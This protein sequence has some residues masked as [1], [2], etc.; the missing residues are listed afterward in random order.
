[1]HNG[2]SPVNRRHHIVIVPLFA[3]LLIIACSR[4]LFL[5]EGERISSEWLVFR[6]NPQHSGFLPLDTSSPFSLRWMYETEGA[7][8]SSPIIATGLVY[9]ASWDKKIH[10]LN[11][12]TGDRIG[13]LRL[14]GSISSTPVMSG[15]RLFV[16]SEHPDGRM[17]AFNMISG[18]VEW[19]TK[20]LDINSSPAVDRGKLFFGSGN[21]ALYAVSTDSGRVLWTFKTGG[22]VRSSPLVT[23]DMVCFG[24]MDRWVYALDAHT[25]E[26]VWKHETR[27]TIDSSPA[28]QNEIVY[29]G[30][31]DSTLYALDTATGNPIWTVQT[32]GSIHSSPAVDESTCY[33]GSYDGSVYAI[34]AQTGDVVWKWSTQSII[35]S[36]PAVSSQAVFI[37][38]HDGSFY[39]IDKRTGTL[40]W[41]YKT[42][43]SITSS[44]ALSSAGIYVGSDDGNVYAFGFREAEG[45]E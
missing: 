19:R 36:S 45:K 21:G 5:P 2:T 17:Y 12:L 26:V 15:A 7:I 14:K 33:I 31:S 29:I 42:E 4:S 43:G 25:G 8:V 11:P 34:R 22:A 18:Q 23:N 32:E 6:G 38:A 20:A 16:G 10:V 3:A 24:S 30:S 13:R 41:T 9:V 35:R 37:G 1:M 27:G 39:V 40:L 44:P 28:V